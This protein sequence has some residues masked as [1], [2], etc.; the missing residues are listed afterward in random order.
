MRLLYVDSVG[1]QSK[2]VLSYNDVLEAH[3]LIGHIQKLMQHA[4]TLG[5]KYIIWN[6]VVYLAEESD[7]RVV[8]ALKKR[9]S[10][11]EWYKSITPA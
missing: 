10:F 11:E 2:G 6:G 5:Y 1:E 3:R 8:E 7:P 9:Y 4:N